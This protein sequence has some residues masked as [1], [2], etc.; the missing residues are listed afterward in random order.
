[1]T[2]PPEALEPFVTA[3]VQ[4]ARSMIENLSHRARSA[5]EPYI[6]MELIAVIDSVG[7]WQLAHL[8]MDI[9]GAELSD[10]PVTDD[11]TRVAAYVDAARRVT[12]LTGAGISTES[13]IRDYRGPNGLWTRNPAAMRQ[14]SIDAYVADPQVRRDAWQER[15]RHPAWAAAPSRGHLALV[16]LE[17]TGKLLALITQAWSA[18]TSHR[19]RPARRDRRRPARDRRHLGAELIGHIAPSRARSSSSAMASW[20]RALGCSGAGSFAP[21]T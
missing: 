6:E 12:V 9:L 20:P 19:C 3:T 17:R 11:L 21:C 14:V 13:G 7:R 1:M 16:A 18:V 10:S 8:M 5:F 15:M 2:S 4:M